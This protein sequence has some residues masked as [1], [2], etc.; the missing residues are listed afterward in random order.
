[1]TD[2]V[3]ISDIIVFCILIIIKDLIRVQS[4]CWCLNELSVHHTTVLNKIKE[5]LCWDRTEKVN[6]LLRSI[7]KERC[8]VWGVGTHQDS[9]PY[10]GNISHPRATSS[11]SPQLLRRDFRQT[12]SKNE[13]QECYAHAPKI[14]DCPQ[15]K[16]TETKIH[17]G[18]ESTPRTVEWNSQEYPPS[19]E[20]ARHLGLLFRKNRDW[21]K[22][23]SLCFCYCCLLG[24]FVCFIVLF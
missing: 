6:L 20:T 4:R 17:D 23:T 14:H 1:M 9:G 7:E 21:E 15:I 3:R 12:L 22:A 5:P 8:S 19:R 24:F 10:T 11:S 16:F 13:S 2:C 18:T